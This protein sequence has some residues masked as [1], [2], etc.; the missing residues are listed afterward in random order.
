MPIVR[1][2]E[3]EHGKELAKWDLPKRMGGYGADGFEPYPRMVYK[4]HRRE[5]GKVMCLDMAALYGE[6]MA[7]VARA[8]AFN[9][10]CHK[11][12]M[13]EEQYRLAKGQGW[14]DTPTEALELFERDAQ[15]LATAAA[16]A[17]YQ[18]QRMTD[19]ARAEFET[20]DAATEHPLADVPAPKRK[21]GRPVK[22]QA[23]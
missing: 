1:S 20:A 13:S 4:A 16:E 15:S 9:A 12:V 2:G 10:S 3:T 23:A 21:P 17:A 19:K 22:A 11:T 7:T 8:E 18:V 6:D 5:N 14:S